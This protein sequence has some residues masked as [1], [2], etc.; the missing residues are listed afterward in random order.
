MRFVLLAMT[1]AGLAGCPG[2]AKDTSTEGEAEAHCE[3]LRASNEGCFEDAQ[4][5]ECVT[6]F[7]EC[8]GPC[9]VLES[10]PVQFACQ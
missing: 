10:C 9:A 5:D 4:F 2:G 8:G 6:C 3:D 1:F 7:E